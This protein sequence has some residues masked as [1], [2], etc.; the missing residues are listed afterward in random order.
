MTLQCVK[1]EGV[2]VKHFPRLVKC[3]K[4]ENITIYVNMTP[5]KNIKTNKF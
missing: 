3:P 4:S 2:D 1:N 5:L